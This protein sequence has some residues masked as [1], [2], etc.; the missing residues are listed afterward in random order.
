M[1]AYKHD[2]ANIKAIENTA[3][4]T[5]CG[6]AFRLPFRRF[7]VFVCAADIH[8]LASDGTYHEIDN[9]LIA[10]KDGSG[11]SI[12]RVTENPAMYCCGAA[13]AP[14]VMPVQCHRRILRWRFPEDVLFGNSVIQEPTVP[15]G[16]S[17]YEYGPYL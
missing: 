17:G 16:I 13:N 8:Y 14:Y 3:L 2:A 10:G 5:P 15:S 1:K 4:H 11:C 7:A 6:K 9:N 12:Y